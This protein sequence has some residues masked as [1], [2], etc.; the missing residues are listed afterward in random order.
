VLWCNDDCFS[1]TFCLR[2]L[3]ACCLVASIFLSACSEDSEDEGADGRNIDQ[4]TP[5]EEREPLLFPPE[6]EFLPELTEPDPKVLDLIRRMAKGC[7]IEAKNKAE[8]ASGRLDG[9]RADQDCLVGYRLAFASWLRKNDPPDV[10]DSLISL[11][12]LQDKAEIQEAALKQFVETFKEL[13]ESS[14]RTNSTSLVAILALKVLM[15]NN[16]PIAVEMAPT[17]TYVSILGGKHRLLY[18]VLDNHPNTKVRFGGYRSL[19]RY[20]RLTTFPH[21]RKLGRSKNI[22]IQVAA[23]GSLLGLTKPNYDEKTVFCPWARQFLKRADSDVLAA[24]GKVMLLCGPKHVSKLIDRGYQAM[25]SN[26]LE[27]PFSLVFSKVCQRSAARPDVGGVCRK[28]FKFL[29]RVANKKELDPEVR[30]QALHSI[31]HQRR[32]RH[33]VK[34]MK[35]YTTHPIKE[36]QAAAT[37]ILITLRATYGF[38]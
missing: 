10:L 24:A 2:S 12:L 36:V 15:A 7:D 27:P 31:F 18:W 21:V 23:L 9:K 22:L 32:D 29:E 5:V 34:L 20:G 16:N 4:V 37:K 28:N 11:Y 3:T 19:M 13:S 17:V 8:V 1:W 38:R 14:R 33:T 35:R 26:T 25:R 6:L 30:A